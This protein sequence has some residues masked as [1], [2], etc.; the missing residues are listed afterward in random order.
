M[1][2][3]SLAGGSPA[4]PGAGREATA[5]ACVAD[6]IDIARGN[7]PPVFGV[8]VAE[9]KEPVVT[10]MASRVGAYYLRF[11]STDSAVTTTFCP[12]SLISSRGQCTCASLQ[13]VAGALSAAGVPVSTTE[14]IDG[15]VVVITPNTAAETGVQ[16][17]MAAASMESSLIR[18]EGPW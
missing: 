1:L 5:S 10:G 13:A 8:P 12:T 17:A 15:N 14:V 11:K 7:V 18:I 4:G 2:S 3:A 16:A 6:I 9:L